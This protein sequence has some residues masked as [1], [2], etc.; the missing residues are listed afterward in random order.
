MDRMILVALVLAIAETAWALLCAAT[1]ANLGLFYV[2]LVAASVV[3][4]IPGLAE[5]R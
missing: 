1:N 2:G 5:K 3:F 4:F